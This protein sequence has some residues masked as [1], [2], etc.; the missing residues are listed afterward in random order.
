M[1]DQIEDQTITLDQIR[2]LSS[3]YEFSGLASN[4]GKPLG[5]VLIGLSDPSKGHSS[6]MQIQ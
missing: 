6:S 2:P 5:S 4:A 1:H 3:L